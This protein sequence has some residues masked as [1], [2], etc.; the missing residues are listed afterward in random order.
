[1][2]FILHG[3]VHQAWSVLHMHGHAVILG[4]E[5]R[6][7]RCF[8]ANIVSDGFAS[9]DL[10]RIFLDFAERSSI[11]TTKPLG[12]HDDHGTPADV[13]HG[14]LVTPSYYTTVQGGLPHI[15]LLM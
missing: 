11:Q 13:A 9:A 4:D 12:Y 5:N 14:L 3:A 8:G 10:L 15:T 6:V 2:V 7:K 1:L